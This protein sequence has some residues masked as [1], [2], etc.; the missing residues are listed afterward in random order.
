MRLRA[1][2]GG[3]PIA[4]YAPVAAV[5]SSHNNP[6]GAGFTGADQALAPSTAAAS[7]VE[8]RARLVSGPIPF[9]R[10]IP[11]F[12]EHPPFGI[13]GVQLGVDWEVGAVRA[14]QAAAGAGGG[15]SA[16]ALKAPFPSCVLFLQ[17]KMQRQCQLLAM[18]LGGVFGKVC[19][20]PGGGAR[21]PAAVPATPRGWCGKQGRRPPRWAD[22]GGNPP[23]AGEIPPRRFRGNLF[24]KTQVVRFKFC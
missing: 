10:D 11:V 8:S 7:L 22:G 5:L 21:A 24:C 9:E 2:C 12:R 13:E 3:R 19:G 1:H 14:E 16:A 4:C 23:L 17:G 18:G 15:L 6:P 20:R